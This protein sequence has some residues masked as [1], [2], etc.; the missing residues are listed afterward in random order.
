MYRLL[1]GQSLGGHVDDELIVSDAVL[2]A[3]LRIA[4]GESDPTLYP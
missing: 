4:P 3:K 2:L 1:H